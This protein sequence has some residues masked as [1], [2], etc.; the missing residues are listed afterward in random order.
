MSYSTQNVSTQWGW[1]R[2]WHKWPRWVGIPLDSSCGH[3]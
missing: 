2:Q 3:L 1:W